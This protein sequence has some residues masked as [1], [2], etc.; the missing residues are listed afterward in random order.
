M[1]KSP[2]DM[3]LRDRSPLVVGYSG[4]GTGCSYASF[5]KEDK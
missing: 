3:I 2:L 5:E 1:A 4:L